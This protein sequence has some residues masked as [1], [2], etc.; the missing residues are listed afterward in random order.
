MA[1]I[2]LRKTSNGNLV[3]QNSLLKTL[4]EPGSLLGTEENLGESDC[5]GVLFWCQETDNKKIHKMLTGHVK[6]QDSDVRENN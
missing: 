1:L 5:G 3:I 4:N 6:N 2:C